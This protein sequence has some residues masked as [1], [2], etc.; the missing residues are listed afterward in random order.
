MPS[1]LS[2]LLPRTTAISGILSPKGSPYTWAELDENLRI[3]YESLIGLVSGGNIQPYN[4]LTV[5]N[6]T[7]PDYVTH[8]GNVWKYINGTPA[9]G[10]TPPTPPATSA[11]W[12]L[13]SVGQWAHQQGTDQF[14]DL[15]GAY[16]VS[17]QE[18]REY[19]DAVWQSVS[20][21]EFSALAL[22]GDIQENTQYY[23][24]DA[25]IPLT[26]VGSAGNG[27]MPAASVRI[28][29]IDTDQVAQ[30]WYPSAPYLADVRVQWNGLVY[31]N[32]TGSNTSTT[33]DADGTNWQVEDPGTVYYKDAYLTADVS[34]QQYGENAG[35]VSINYITDQ[36]GNR[37][38]YALALIRKFHFSVPSQSIGNDFVGTVCD[39]LANIATLTHSRALAQAQLFTE[40]GGDGTINACEFDGC[41][42]TLTGKLDGELQHCKFKDCIV[43]IPAGLATGK[44]IRGLTVIGRNKTEDS[45]ALPDEALE[46]GGLVIFG[47]SSTL[48]KTID[49]SAAS[50]PA[51]DLGNHD[52]FGEFILENNPGSGP[53]SNIVNAPQGIPEFIIRPIETEDMDIATTGATSAVDGDLIYTGAASTYGLRGNRGDYVRCKRVEFSGKVVYSVEIF[54]HS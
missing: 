23:L 52:G 7:K 54:N 50:P 24:N 13:S 11:Y 14:L 32:L 28:L 49:L 10:Q 36:N 1:L 19:L 38:S 45:L 46:G 48:K 21:A 44:T 43:T 53:F 25:P 6:D 40:S 30:T 31:K 16:Q 33:P 2:Q 5:Y 42:F 9:A 20:V 8:G 27:I 17:A 26:V 29:V 4:A 51:L 12:E 41:T 15:G 47:K 39:G 37:W 3:F 35:T 22:G 34:L 18:I